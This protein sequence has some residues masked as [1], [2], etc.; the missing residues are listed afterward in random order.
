MP[1]QFLDLSPGGGGG[2]RQVSDE[3]S[4]SSTEE[5]TQP[6]DDV[7]LSG[8]KRV[9]SPE[10]ENWA[11]NKSPKL[12][13]PKPGGEPQPSSSD[14]AMRKARVSVR[15]RSEAPMVSEQS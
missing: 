1:R 8:N 6:G 10:P 13:P 4:N 5:R 14:A 11:P 7:V 12:N 15:A 2:V 3:Q 9:E